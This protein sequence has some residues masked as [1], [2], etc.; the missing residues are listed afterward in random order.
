[1]AARYPVDDRGYGMRFFF[2][3]AFIL[4]FPVI[5]RLEHAHLR[6]AFPARYPMRNPSRMWVSRGRH[7]QSHAQAKL[8]CTSVITKL[9]CVNSCMRRSNGDLPQASS[10]RP[11]HPSFITN[12]VHF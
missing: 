4:W 12:T 7:G 11:N 3:S 1:V 8:W 9:C 2:S 6:L 5:R 10:N